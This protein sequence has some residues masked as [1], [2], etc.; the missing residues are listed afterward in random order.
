MLSHDL[1]EK[2]LAV[3]ENLEIHLDAALDRCKL[4]V[5]VIE[6]GL[7][8]LF[9]D[10]CIVF[11]DGAKAQWDDL[12]LLHRLQ[13]DRLVCQEMRPRDVQALRGRITDDCYKVGEAE[14]ACRMLW[15]TNGLGLKR[16][17]LVLKRL[18]VGDAVDV[19]A[20]RRG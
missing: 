6:R 7:Q 10:R 9:D 18:G 1:L 15:A 19:G 13:D 11:G 14:E 12:T 17:V 2:L 16:R 3:P 8:K 5:Q 20:Q 4:L